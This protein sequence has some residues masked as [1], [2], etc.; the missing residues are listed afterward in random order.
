[1]AVDLS[2]GDRSVSVSASD[3]DIT[4]ASVVAMVDALDRLSALTGEEAAS[5]QVG[6]ADD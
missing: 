5:T 2:R 3:A 1:V 6:S 4:R